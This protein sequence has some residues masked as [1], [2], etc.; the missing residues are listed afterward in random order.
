MQMD[1][2][3]DTGDIMIQEE[4]IID[5]KDTGKTLYDKLA[6]CGSNL[7]LQALD[8]LEQ[9]EITRTKQD[10]DKATYVKTIDKSLG[11]INFYQPAIEIER[12]IRGL[13]PWPSAYTSINGKNLK[14]WEA[15]VSDEESKGMP[16]EIINLKKDSIVVK[17]GK[18]NLKL[19][20]IQL[21]GK[22]RM[23]TE[24]FLRGYTVEIGTCLGNSLRKE[25]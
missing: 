19:K 15:E 13:N 2:G 23:K 6:I 8:L 18:G 10:D 1:S 9:G 22:K 11:K 4:V 21:E 12:L 25:N 20:E 14:I 7:I 3:L 17:T 16:G 24:D 5:E